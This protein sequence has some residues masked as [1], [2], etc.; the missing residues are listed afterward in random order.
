LFNAL[1]K[2]RYLDLVQFYAM[3]KYV[4][5]SKASPVFDTKQLTLF[6]RWLRVSGN[7]IRNTAFDS[8]ADFA[9]AV[10]S[11]KQLLGEGDD[12]YA[13]L[14]NKSIQKISFFDR[15]QFKEEVLKAA[16]CVSDAGWE[17]SL[18]KVE[19]N[20]YF[21]GQI[22]FL[23]NLSIDNDNEVRVRDR[24]AFISYGN[25]ASNIFSGLL[26]SDS[27]LLQRALL[28]LGDYLIRVNSNFSFCRNIAGNARDRNENWRK[29]FNDKND[30]QKIFKDLL[31]QLEEGS[32]RQGL[33][34]IIQNRV[35][36]D[37]RE[38][39]IRYPE[40]I[41]CC[42][43]LQARFVD[44]ENDAVY[45]LKGVRMSGNYAELRTYALYWELKNNTDSSLAELI[46]TMQPYSFDKGDEGVPGVWFKD[47]QDSYL[48]IDFD[49]EFSIGRY[50]MDDNKMDFVM[51][52]NNIQLNA[53]KVIMAKVANLE[54]SNG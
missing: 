29:V 38:Y 17:E 11:L 50:D 48:F 45:L 36:R 54:V 44:N 22:G 5:H 12:I 34:S 31:D 13:S 15:E 46:K 30:R 35:L 10:Q 53:L 28:S 20:A 14:A 9:R 1:A 6:E 39:F 3:F 27:F 8:S 49:E 7:L 40:C 23:L 18:I 51:D 41:E 26:E 4:T 43:K 42:G 33:Q 32:E 25:K 47:K 37:W 21:Y 52:E 24:K 16:L 19:N 2:N